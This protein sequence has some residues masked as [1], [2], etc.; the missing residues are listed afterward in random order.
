MRV[1]GVDSSPTLIELCRQRLPDREWLVADMRELSL[2]RTFDGIFAWDSFFHL[3][4]AD[5]RAM[6]DLFSAPSSASTILIFKAGPRSGEAIGNCRGDPLY[7]SSLDPN[8][9]AQ[10]LIRHGFETIDHAIEDPLAGGR[11]VWLAGKR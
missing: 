1:T 10:L 6:F 4:P 8:E 7:H 11:T 2:A 3:C 5:Q 9:Y